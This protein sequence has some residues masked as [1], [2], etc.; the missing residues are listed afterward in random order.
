MDLRAQEE[1]L[2]ALVRKYGRRWWEP[3]KAELKKFK[4]E[5][6]EWLDSVAKDSRTNY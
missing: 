2:R 5:G 1:E 4:G 3:W 6:K